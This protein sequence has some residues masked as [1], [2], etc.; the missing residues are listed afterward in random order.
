MNTRRD[1]LFVLLGV[2]LFVGRRLYTGPLE[3]LIH[4]YAGNVTVSFAVYFIVKQL[5]LRM[6]YVELVI[7]CI[8]MGAVN[9]F[10]ASDGFW[11]MANTYD[12]Y[13]VAANSVGVGIALVV[14]ILLKYGRPGTSG[15]TRP[16]A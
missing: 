3:L 5:P 14:D 9:L 12:P 7:A 1:L 11:V 16:A 10:E 4:N 2:L 8:A 6:P 13:D 15:P